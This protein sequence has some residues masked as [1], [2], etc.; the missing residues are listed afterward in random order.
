MIERLG[1]VGA[2][3]DQRIL[4]R[5]MR[6]KGSPKDAQD[7]NEHHRGN[8]HE[9]ALA[10]A[11]ARGSRGVRS[12]G[13]GSDFLSHRHSIPRA[14]AKLPMARSAPARTQFVS[15]RLT[16]RSLRR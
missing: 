1:V 12:T 8:Q 5:S 14:D 10:G 2:V 7:E 15:E 4:E 13:H 6:E 9:A 3:D 16:Y 11:E